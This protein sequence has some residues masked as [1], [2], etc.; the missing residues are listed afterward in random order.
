MCLTFLKCDFESAAYLLRTGTLQITNTD[1]QIWVCFCSKN[2]LY[3][4]CVGGFILQFAAYLQ[5]HI[6]VGG[7]RW[8]FPKVT[9]PLFYNNLT[10]QWA[11]SITQTQK[12]GLWNRS[13]VLEQYSVITVNKIRTTDTAY[14]CTNNSN[15]RRVHIYI[16]TSGMVTRQQCE[17]T[18][19]FLINKIKC[20]GKEEEDEKLGLESEMHHSGTVHQYH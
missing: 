13:S 4:K 17:V 18:E 15:Y 12:E 16:Y 9:H 6:A 14:F 5:G 3:W 11:L 8:L 1:T 19:L 20:G 2:T 10:T 7:H